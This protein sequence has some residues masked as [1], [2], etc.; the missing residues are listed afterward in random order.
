MTHV[1]EI[2]HLRHG[3]GQSGRKIEPRRYPNSFFCGVPK[4]VSEL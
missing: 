2:G 4:L 3:V 1:S